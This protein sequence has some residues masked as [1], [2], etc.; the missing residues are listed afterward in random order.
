MPGTGYAEPLG[1][2][3]CDLGES[4]I[5]DE[6]RS[7]LWGIDVTAPAIWR[8]TL[9][10]RHHSI[11]IERPI[12][13]LALSPKALVCVQRNQ[14]RSYDPEENAFAD[15]WR[16]DVF[17]GDQRF[18]D[19][20]VDPAGA[21]WVGGMD[22][23]VQAPLGS[24]FR[25]EGGVPAAFDAGFVLG[26][27]LAWSPDARTQY[28]VDTYRSTVWRYPWAREEGLVGPRTLHARTEGPGHPDGCAIDEAGCLWVAM[29][30]GGRIDRIDP[31]G[32][33]AESIRLPVSK[34]TSCA[35]GDADRRTLFITTARMG[36]GEATLHDEPGAGAVF[37]VRVTTPGLAQPFVT[38]SF[39]QSFTQ[40][41][42][43]CK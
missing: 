17:L 11:P 10:G 26:N 27:G 42:Q 13:A 2:L 33:V 28:F 6:R 39:T 35:F 3:R 8:M 25:F 12:G 37:A 1:E 24:L 14:I 34:P 29:A 7:C 21:L 32:R 40:S 22:R 16:D 20:G 38:Q 31:S 15:L 41:S 19:A 43:E 9:D 23:R 18:N 30:G 4:P 36:L 5:W